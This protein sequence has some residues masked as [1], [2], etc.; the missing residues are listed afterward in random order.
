LS[1]K[2]VDFGRRTL[3]LAVS[4]LL[5]LEGCDAMVQKRQITEPRSY[6]LLDR[7]SPY[8]KAHLK[9][10]NL[11]VFSQWTVD[12]AGQAITGSG[13][14]YDPNRTV[15]NAGPMTLPIDSVALFETNRVHTSGAIASLAVLTGV[16]AVFAIV[17]ITDPKTCFGSC[18]TFYVT[19]GTQPLLQAEGFSS[20]VAPALE[21]RDIDALYRAHPAGR[22]LEVV[23][24]N[25]AME[26][27]VIRYADI[28][29][30]PRE[31]GKRVFATADGQFYQAN[32]LIPPEH[33]FAEE[34]DCTDL[35]YA[36]DGLER[37]STADST[38]LATRETIDLQFDSIPSGSCGMVIGSRQT[39]LTTF[40]FYQTLAYMGTQASSWMALLER[41][42]ERTKSL[43]GGLGEA[44][45]WI[46]VQVP[47]SSGGWKTVG[48]T[49]ETGPL[50]ADVRVVPLP[51]MP[52]GSKQ[53][54]L[55]LTKGHWRL[56]YLALAELGKR[57]DPIRIA[58]HAAYRYG[59]TDSVALGIMNDTLAPLV[60]T[61]G[62]EYKFV[63]ELP[64]DF[65]RYELFMM[66]KGYYLEWMRQEW[67]AE[68]N[69]QKAMLMFTHPDEA[70][71]M[72]APEFKKVEPVIEANFW[73]SRYARP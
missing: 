7:A 5:I 61:A 17:C 33:A 10:G 45:G 51:E 58:P 69:P 32:R 44:L 14:R 49:R 31:D 3:A 13:T 34:G 36:F 40:L 65:D 66:S 22:D 48:M 63:Y 50:A 2:V 12:S 73:G 46:E 6:M 53:I 57:V 15:L 20:S 30:A 24:K 55:C 23:M 72:L 4:T 37:F 47:D 27:Q 59:L 68:E 21:R 70:M 62:D 41:N 60:T 25:E 8:L 67:M 35:V 52:R 1:L 56:D 42:K 29:A 43:S 9:S 26:T 39:L 38:D 54:R 64:E 11:V 16:T 28:L 71:R 19:D 18:P